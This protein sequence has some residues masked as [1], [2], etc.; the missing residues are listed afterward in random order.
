MIA[1]SA[2]SQAL[3][4]TSVET[5]TRRANHTGKQTDRQP[6]QETDTKGDCMLLGIV[7]GACMA[8]TSQEMLCEISLLVLQ[9]KDRAL[10]S[11]VSAVEEVSIDRQ[12]IQW[13]RLPAELLW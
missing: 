4:Q 1:G 6:Q 11:Y 10:C 8:G 5:D 3:L 2:A 13:P 12:F 7:S 9:V